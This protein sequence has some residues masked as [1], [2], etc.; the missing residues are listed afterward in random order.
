MPTLEVKGVDW[1]GAHSGLLG[2]HR[3]T[4]T[5]PQ[6]TAAALSVGAPLLNIPLSFHAVSMALYKALGL[7]CAVDS[8]GPSL[9]R[10]AEYTQLDPTEKANISFWTGMTFA[11]LVAEHC[12]G[13]PSV[14]HVSSMIRSGRAT[15]SPGSHV[16]AD[17]LGQDLNGAWHVVEAKARQGSVSAGDRANWKAQT[18]TIASVAG[19]SPS[20]RSYCLTR[21]GD[22]YTVELVD[23]PES[24]VVKG[25]ELVFSQGA[26]VDFYYGPFRDWLTTSVADTAAPPP[27]QIDRGVPL[28]VRLAAFDPNTQLY[29]FAGMRSDVLEAVQAGRTPEPTLRSQS[30]DIDDGYVRADGIAIVSSADASLT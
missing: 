12:L 27:F 17:L 29:W 2:R 28:T 1:S 11:A 3:L 19:P 9:V 20:T 18:G 8:N 13:V 16:V 25:G 23:P 14:W 6:I 24:E 4:V 5:G 22:P 7:V 15:L 26:V 21:V 30:F 10:P